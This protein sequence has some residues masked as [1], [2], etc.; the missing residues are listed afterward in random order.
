MERGKIKF[1][2]PNKGYGFI[3][4]DG[5]KEEIFLHK[6]QLEKSGYNDITVGANISY[7]LYIDKKGKPKATNIKLV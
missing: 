4:P 1:Y 5:S 7:E 2:N 6:S 3:Y